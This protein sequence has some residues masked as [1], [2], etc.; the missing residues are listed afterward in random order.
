MTLLQRLA[1]H[2]AATS[3]PP[4]YAESRVAW[5]LN[6]SSNGAEASLEPVSGP[7]A[8]PVCH[9][10][11]GI[12]PRLAADHLSYVLGWSDK[13]V[14]E[15]RAQRCHAAF[16]DLLTRF[17]ATTDNP[18]VGCAVEWFAA[19]APVKPPDQWSAREVAVVAVDGNDVIDSAQARDFWLATV[20]DYKGSGR[21][22]ICLVCGEH[23]SLIS[24]VPTMVPPHLLPGAKHNA[25]LV[26]NNIPAAHYGSTHGLE[27]S[28]I[29][30][31]CADRFMSG[32]LAALTS[33]QRVLVPGQDVHHCW[34]Y[35]GPAPST[36]WI[37]IS[38]RPGTASHA[39]DLDQLR[40]DRDTSP[41]ESRVCSLILSASQARVVVQHWVDRPLREVLD[42]LVTWWERIE[43]PARGGT[44][45]PT[46]AGMVLAC[47]D[48]D[49]GRQVYSQPGSHSDRRSQW[50]YRQLA[51]A[52]LDEHGVPRSVMAQLLRQIKIDGHVN[53]TRA[54]ILK[55][56]QHN[57]PL[58]QHQ[59][60]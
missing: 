25:A 22:G 28:P 10:T 35:T 51:I 30:V 48:Y 46:T 18:A 29:C 2:P 36:D 20:A 43:I 37:E 55:G 40:R 32:L 11:A 47:G 14:S 9:R 60:G 26:S 12:Q 33:E 57:Q 52:A 44:D 19:G 6:I 54:A 45:I 15:T 41:P 53:S 50:L 24:S 39:A 5:R 42:S 17:A 56:A 58:A 7:I 21:T 8:V 23:N 34:W 1:A 49:R 38:S 16:V 27:S 59:L 13:S 3:Y 4:F 31:T